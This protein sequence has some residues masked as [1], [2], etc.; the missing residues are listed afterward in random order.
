MV[1]SII[2]SLAMAQAPLGSWGVETVEMIRRDFY[3]PDQ[4]LYAEE[5]GS[6]QPCF[7]WGTG[8][9]LSAL[10]AAARWDR[11]Y[12]PWLDEYAT[13]SRIYWND[14]GPVPGYD[15]LPGPKPV[16]RYYDD[17]EWMALQLS[18]PMSCCGAINI[19]GGPKRRWRTF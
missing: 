14:R 18:R 5:A 2:A 12:M 13:A 9:M 11:K 1:A 17:N 8:V 3:L 15:V 16:D 7:N 19:S 6:K 10:N 4:L